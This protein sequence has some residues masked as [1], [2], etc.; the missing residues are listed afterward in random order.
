MAF[1]SEHLTGLLAT[2]LFEGGAFP[3]FPSGLW[4]AKF[5]STP[6]RDGSGGTESAVVPRTRIDVRRS[7]PAWTPTEQ[8]NI[9][10]VAPVPYNGTFGGQPQTSQSAIIGNSHAFQTEAATADETG[11]IVSFGIYDAQTNGNLLFQIDSAG[12]ATYRPQLGQRIEFAA[13]TIA[14]G[15]PFVPAAITASYFAVRWLQ[16]IIQED[17]AAALP[18]ELWLTHLTAAPTDPLGTGIAEAQF[19]PRLEITAAA[20]GDPVN[21]QVRNET[22]MV[23]DA[24]TQDEPAALIAAAIY[25]SNTGGGETNNFLF[26][27]SYPANVTV[28][29]TATQQVRVP[30][31][32]LRFGIL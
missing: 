12:G 15:I 1:V 24:T 17:G 30:E 7:V 14:I 21:Q 19:T 27:L 10:Q 6:Q 5:H 31:Q 22:A 2:W 25:D 18:T 20:I 26:H 32:G 29:P 28:T 3:T 9:W 16:R 11:N 4:L 8:A 23:H 13:N